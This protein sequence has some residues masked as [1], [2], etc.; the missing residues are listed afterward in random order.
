M[1]NKNQTGIEEK[2]E[3]KY[4]N[5]YGIDI[6]DEDVEYEYG[7]EEESGTKTINLGRKRLGKIFDITIETNSSYGL[8]YKITNQDEYKEYLEFVGSGREDERDPDE[9]GG[10]TENILSFKGI[11]TG[12]T[13][14]IFEFNSMTG[15]QRTE[16]YKVRIVRWF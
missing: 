1:G 11:K 4:R 7:F 10:S 13:R 3:F 16:I 14:I 9:Y 2:D 8:N 6:E 15:G 12:K 5:K